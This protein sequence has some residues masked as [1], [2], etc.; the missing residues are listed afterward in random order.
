MIETFADAILLAQN[1]EGLEISR[2][3]LT[4]IGLLIP[5]VIFLIN[6][7]DSSDGLSVSDE[8]LISRFSTGTAAFGMQALI[9]ALVGIVANLYYILFS[10]VIITPFQMSL[11]SVVGIS[12]ISIITIVL[13]MVIMLYDY[14]WSIRRQRPRR[15]RRRIHQSKIREYE[16]EK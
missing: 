4:V 11:L 12:S 13:I 16:K 2:T 9:F 15:P 14:N 6:I 5:A 8:R 3:L 7:F 10:H 1:S